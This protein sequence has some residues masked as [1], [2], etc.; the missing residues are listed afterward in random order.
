[1]SDIEKAMAWLE[2]A[3]GAGNQH[4]I[5]ADELERLRRRW[6]QI[7]G[8]PEGSRHLLCLLMPEKGTL[9]DFNTMIDR[10]INSKAGGEK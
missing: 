10:I 3:A 1:M 9:D 8:D 7:T 2:W 6:D 4:K 5:I